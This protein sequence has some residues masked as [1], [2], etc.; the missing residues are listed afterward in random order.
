MLDFTDLI[1]Y[2]CPP[3]VRLKVCAYRTV[4]KTVVA[5][6]NEAQRFLAKSY[7]KAVLEGN[8]T[9]FFT[10]DFFRQSNLPGPLV[11]IPK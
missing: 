1:R 2:Q 4:P 8:S 5:M 11:Y 7:Y 10:F 3:T 9:R 6:N